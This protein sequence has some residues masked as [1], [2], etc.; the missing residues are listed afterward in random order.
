M[1]KHMNTLTQLWDVTIDTSGTQQ[2]IESI[3]T[4]SNNGDALSDI[5]MTTL[6]S[7]NNSAIFYMLIFFWILVMIRTIKDSNYRSHN[8]GFVVLSLLLVTLGT[9]L[10]GLPLYLAIRPLGYK[11]E[12]SYWKAVMTQE[13]EDVLE[14]QYEI[15]TLTQD[16]SDADEDHLADLKKQATVSKRRVTRATTKKWTTPPT[17]KTSSTVKN[18]APV[19]NTTPKKRR[20]PTRTTN[21]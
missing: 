7:V 10:L 1:I 13:D 5:V 2:M 9:P 8:T 3:I 15:K 4:N 16:S 20:T 18:T 17:K 12:R 19:N 11:Y 6:W 14:E 21:L